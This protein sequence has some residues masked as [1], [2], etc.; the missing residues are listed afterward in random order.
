MSHTKGNQNVKRKLLASTALAVAIILGTSSAAFAHDCLNLSRPHNGATPFETQKGRWVA[1]NLEE[2]GG[3]AWLFLTPDNF[4]NVTSD[5]LLGNAACP[6]GRLA[7]QSQGSN[8]PA[9]LNGIW[10]REC[11]EKA[12]G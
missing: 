6:S 7:G 3:D 10:S 12:S 9:D 1:I 5:A 4:M 8:Y 2:V 11:F